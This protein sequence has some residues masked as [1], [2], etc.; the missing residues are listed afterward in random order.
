[1]RERGCPLAVD[2]TRAARTKKASLD[3]QFNLSHAGLRVDGG[4]M[5]APGGGGGGGAMYPI[6][7]GGGMGGP[8]G[9]PGYPIGGPGEEGGDRKEQPVR[10]KMRIWTR[11]GGQVV[12]HRSKVC[13]KVDKLKCY[14]PLHICFHFEQ[15]MALGSVTEDNVDVPTH[16]LP[17]ALA[18]RLCHGWF[19]RVRARWGGRSG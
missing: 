18:G 15:M 8:G 7:P 17:E 3:I 5:A 1:M 9:Y 19:V 4:G 2:I 16:L 12:S 6:M 13:W 11:V 10:W 14:V